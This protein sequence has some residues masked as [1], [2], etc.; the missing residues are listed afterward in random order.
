MQ[1]AFIWVLLKRLIPAELFFEAAAGMSLLL[2]VSNV[3][4]FW[5]GAKDPLNFRPKGRVTANCREEG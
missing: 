2:I 5:L 1:A 3:L 4:A